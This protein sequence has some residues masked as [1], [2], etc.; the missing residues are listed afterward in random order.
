MY[1]YSEAVAECSLLIT[2]RHSRCRVKFSH[3]YDNPSK[4]K[5]VIFLLF[6]NMNADVELTLLEDDPRMTKTLSVMKIDSFFTG[7]SL[8]LQT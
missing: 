8:M 3:F 1:L 7:L 2:H 6:L 5:V 4:S